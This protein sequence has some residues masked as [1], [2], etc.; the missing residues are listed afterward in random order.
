VARDYYQRVLAGAA[1]HYHQEE[2][3]RL[4]DTPYRQ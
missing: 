1:A 2:A 3:R 4:L